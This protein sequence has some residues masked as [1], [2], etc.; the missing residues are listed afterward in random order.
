MSRDG[1]QP[2]KLFTFDPADY[3]ETEADR[4]QFMAEAIKTGD[5]GYIERCRRTVERSK[6][7]HAEQLPGS[8]GESS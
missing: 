5:D 4:K 8:N 6:L 2:E 3:L 7:L 1:M